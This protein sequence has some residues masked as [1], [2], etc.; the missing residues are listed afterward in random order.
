[1]VFHVKFR[2]LGK[3]PTKPF[4]LTGFA[5]ARYLRCFACNLCIT[6]KRYRRRD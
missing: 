2:K 4:D 6:V 5:A 3:K 1:M